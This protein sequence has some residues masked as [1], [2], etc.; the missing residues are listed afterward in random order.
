MSRLDEMIPENEDKLA[1]LL[2]VR[3]VLASNTTTK[4]TRL[5]ISYCKRCGLRTGSFILKK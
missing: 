2:G 3:G 1:W 5:T 4:C